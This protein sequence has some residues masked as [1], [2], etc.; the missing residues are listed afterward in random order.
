M[1]EQPDSGDNADS[2]VPQGCAL[3]LSLKLSPSEHKDMRWCQ[4]LT[5]VFFCLTLYIIIDALLSGATG[6]VVMFVGVCSMHAVVHS[7]MD[8]KYSTIGLTGGAKYGRML[9]LVAQNFSQLRAFFDAEECLRTGQVGMGFNITAMVEGL[10]KNV[11]LFC[12]DIIFLLESAKTTQSTGEVVIAI[13][14]ALQLI[15]CV[16]E[17]A[18]TVV[19][20]EILMNPNSVP[21]K[22]RLRMYFSLDVIA[23]GLSTALITFTLLNSAG[24]SG[25]EWLPAVII[26]GNRILLFCV[27]YISRGFIYPPTPPETRDSTA[28]WQKMLFAIFPAG[29]VQVFNDF[30][31]N[32]DLASKASFFAMHQFISWSESAAMAL[33][34]FTAFDLPGIITL[35]G[36]PYIFLAVWF[37]A[38]STKG[39]LFTTYYKARTGTVV[40]HASARLSKGSLD[41]N[42]ANAELL[43][44]ERLSKSGVVIYVKTYCP[45]C[46][47]MRAFLDTSRPKD[48]PEETATVNID[49]CEE[50][51]Q[52]GLMT[53]LGGV[54]ASGKVILP[55][56]F[57]NRQY[58]GGFNELK[59]WRSEE[60]DV[61]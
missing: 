47:Q 21:V 52:A 17:T 14:I 60:P 22:N 46:D 9:V 3:E 23:R 24:G 32:G 29:F 31:F 39:V 20:F 45:V 57:I 55:M 34:P 11:P 2:V 58:V 10:V 37:V 49:E 13:L 44:N 40:A 4:F 5:I 12:A 59:G 35:Y 7:I 18:K 48:L 25:L 1:A 61:I 16:D 28:A 42:C 30:P 19:G 56:I 27:L 36:L 41:E 38:F 54:H 15:W 51:E 33:I 26:Y 8:W 43:H 6:T 53:F 50:A